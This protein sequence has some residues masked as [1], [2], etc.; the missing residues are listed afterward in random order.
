[1]PDYITTIEAAE[2]SGYNTEYIR[3]MIRAGT[4]TAVKRGRDWWVDRKSFM[5]YLRA[6]R[7]H[8]KGHYG[9]Q[10]PPA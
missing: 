7:R 2:L 1:M 5:G 9:P 3:Q 6:V 10:N 8:K 4:I